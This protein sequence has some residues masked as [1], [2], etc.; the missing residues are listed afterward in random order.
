[1][2]G[3]FGDNLFG[4]VFAGRVLGGLAIGIVAAIVAS[5]A[6][7]ASRRVADSGSAPLRHLERLTSA[8]LAGRLLVAAV[9]A[10]TF[11]IRTRG[12]SDHFFL[13]G[14]QIRDWTIAL[15]PFANLPLVGA[16][17]NGGGNSFGP[18]YY[19]VLWASRVTIGP[20]VDNLPHA[21]GIGLAAAQSFA[22]AVLW[23]EFEERAGRGC[24]RLR[25][26]W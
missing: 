4:T 5:I 8:P 9:A 16:P 17:S 10:Y 2:R 12:L 26:C 22:D 25:P 19:W 7:A 20:L 1:M 6:V 14:D 13:M 24:L 3:F 15:G 11:W 23:T 18:V 21:G